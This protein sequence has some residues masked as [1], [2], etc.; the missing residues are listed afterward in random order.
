[1]EKSAACPKQDVC[2]IPTGAYGSQPKLY[3]R[4]AQHCEATAP[5]TSSAERGALSIIMPLF[6]VPDKAS[7]ERDGD[8]HVQDA[9]AVLAGSGLL[10]TGRSSPRR[11]VSKVLSG[12]KYN[13]GR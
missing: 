8:K 7:D 1:M 9:S 6:T 4:T 12:G 11:T 5:E 3:S 13:E 10:Y 2:G